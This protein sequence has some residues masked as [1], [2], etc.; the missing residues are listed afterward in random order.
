MNL[1]FDDRCKWSDH[2]NDRWMVRLAETIKRPW[3]AGIAQTFA[4]TSW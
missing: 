3:Q 1:I 4:I 2:T